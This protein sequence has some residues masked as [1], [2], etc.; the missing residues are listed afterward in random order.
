[1]RSGVIRTS[2]R[3]LRPCRSTSCAAAKGIRWVNPSIATQSPSWTCAA[4]ASEREQNAG[5]RPQAVTSVLK[6][7][8]LLQ[9]LLAPIGEERWNLHGRAQLLIRLIDQEALGLGHGRFEQRSTRGAHI[10]RVEVAAILHFRHIGKA[11]ALEME[12]HLALRLMIGDLERDMMRH[13]FAV[14]P[15]SRDHIRFDAKFN[16]GATAP[17]A[18]LITQVP[19][20]ASDAPSIPATLHE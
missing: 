4:M 20:V 7:L 12:F 1:M 15:A 16:D 19:A 14:G 3:C 6:R 5:M 10:N 2:V 13:T 8:D 11:E 9:Q 17:I 18:H